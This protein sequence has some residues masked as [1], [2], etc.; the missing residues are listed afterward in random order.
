MSKDDE[1]HDPDFE[2]WLHGFDDY[3]TEDVEIVMLAYG[4]SEW[5]L[6]RYWLDQR[7]LDMDWTVERLV[8][9]ERPS[10]EE[11]R[12]QFARRRKMLRD[13]ALQKRANEIVL[14][15]ISRLANGLPVNGLMRLCIHAWCHRQLHKRK[16]GNRG[17]DFVE[18]VFVEN[19]IQEIMDRTGGRVPAKE[20]ARK[21]NASENTPKNWKKKI[22]G[23]AK[24]K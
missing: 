15:D 4:E 13:P 7:F 18:R 20:L 12:E 10:E 14:R 22:L 16:R 2:D 21:L 8:L 9:P 6:Y 1:E 17:H 24:D 3:V 11:K 5:T 19:K 23:S